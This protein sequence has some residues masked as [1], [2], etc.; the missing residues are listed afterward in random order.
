MKQSRFLLFALLWSALCYGSSYDAPLPPQL[1]TDP[2][3]CAF[4]PCREVMPGAEGFSV[5]QGRPSYVEAYR[6]SGAQRQLIGYVFLSTDIVDIPAYSGKPVVTLIG[7]DTKGVISGVRILKHSE[8]ILLVGIPEGELDKFIA[9]YVGKFAGA[10]VE[11]GKSSAG[12]ERIGLDAIS[13]ATVTVIAENQVVM[14]SAYAIAKQVGIVK[15]VPKAAARF[16]PQTANRDWKALVAEGSVQH[17]TVQPDEL[18]IP[19]SGQPYID[20]YFGYLNAPVVGRSIL[21][22][23]GWKRLMSELKADEHAIFIVANGTASFKGSG[24]VRGGIYDRIQVAQDLDSHTFRDTDYQNLYGIAAAGSPAYKESAIFILRGG[25][26]SAA[27][28]WSLVFLANKVDRATGSKTFANFEREYWL[29][30]QYLEGG[31]P[32]VLRP[33]PTW[34]RV[35][36]GKPLVIALFVLLLAATAGLYAR[37]DWLVRKASRK[38][39]RWVSIPKYVVWTTSIVFVGFYAL[40]QPSIT[41]VLTWLHSLVYQWRWE[42]F[43][44]DPLIF[45]FWLFIAATIFLWGRG[46]FCGWLCPYGS[47]SELSFK[48]AGALGLK[49]FQF[50]LPMVWHNRLRWLKYGIFALLVGVSFYDIGLAEQMAEVEPFKST[51]LVGGVWNRA[52]PFIAYWAALFVLGLFVE[53]P[54]CKYLC[55]LGAGLAIPTTF[56]FIKLKRKEECTTCHACQKGCGSLAIADDGRIDQRECLLCLECQILYYDAHTCPPLSQERRRRTKSGLELTP[57]GDD[58][59]YIPIKAVR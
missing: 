36:Q 21:G 20:L 29:P 48:I 28:P 56:R 1:S 35:W 42:L 55:P 11:I 26:F 23:A 53:R 18:G 25:H 30:D 12:D 59:Y 24:F 33:D 45:I 22:E 38:D 9:Q 14:R 58:G 10:K 34:L 39:K 44:S 17:L 13:G 15:S 46:L 31:R 51:F 4:A 47:L 57:I 52:W 3:L 7:M 49:R 2:D 5:R 37:R 32:T 16:T 8:P 54:F 43:L 41:H 6:G 50:H 40:A 19:G 27:Y